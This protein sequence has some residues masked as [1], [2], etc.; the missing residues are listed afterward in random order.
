M[1]I[2]LYMIASLIFICI[3]FYACMNNPIKITPDGIL[4]IEKAT[5]YQIE[6]EKLIQ[7]YHLPSL[8]V[9]VV[10]DKKCVYSAGF[11]FA[12]IENKIKATDSTP[13]Q[14]ASVTKP[15]AASIILGL[16]EQGLIDLHGKMKDYYPE[17]VKS[18]DEFYNK[19]KENYPN[20]MPIIENYN[21]KTEEITIWHHLTHTSEGKPGEHFKYSGFLY[22]TLSKVV[23]AAS[24]KD[25]RTI[26]SEDIF[27]RLDMENSM[28]DAYDTSKPDVL[29][30]LAKPYII[31]EGGN[32]VLNRNY[33]ASDLGAGGGIIST[34]LDLVKFD[35]A[36]DSH[37]IISQSSRDLAYTP[38]KSND[39]KILPY[40]IGWFIG[41][42]KGH[43][44]VYH[45]GWDGPAYSALY[46]K[47]L[48]SNLTLILLSNCEN[49]TAPFM[50][51]LGKGNIEYSPFAKAFLVTFLK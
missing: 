9:A 44:V 31:D 1:K 47:V 28:P 21:Y 33:R 24:K 43:K 7:E 38:A 40:G 41:N 14:I 5:T 23:D 18:F 45:T 25:F 11:G 48:D 42:Y 29:K 17:Y 49:L 26:L 50:E 6:L 2:K 35:I 51:E 12:D 16:S 20:M 13:Y 8:S 36:Y 4:L 34:V 30:N 15:I 37:E 10:K 27:K 3:I 32:A 39:G 46:L 19:I 22:S